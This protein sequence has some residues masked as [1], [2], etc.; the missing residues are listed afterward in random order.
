[1]LRVATTLENSNSNSTVC[2]LSVFCLI[3]RPGR[4][5]EGRPHSSE[6]LRHSRFQPLIAESMFSAHGSVR[7][8]KPPSLQGICSPLAQQMLCEG[9]EWSRHCSEYN[10]SAAGTCLPCAQEIP[11]TWGLT[12][13][14]TFRV[15]AALVKRDRHTQRQ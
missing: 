3:P 1:M 11:G 8:L 6:Q 5:Q 15:V 14:A 7:S 12:F 2:P 9:C 4:E 10:C 13:R